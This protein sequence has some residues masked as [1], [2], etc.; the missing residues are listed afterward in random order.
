M[1]YGA[2]L[3]DILEAMQLSEEEADAI[4]ARMDA[5]LEDP[6]T[7]GQDLDLEHGTKL[8]TACDALTSGDPLV[9]PP[10]TSSWNEASRSEIA[11]SELKHQIQC[12]E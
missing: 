5:V 10:Y 7:Q 1:S 8:W 6:H 11:P 2:V 4:R 3:V 12:N 9:T